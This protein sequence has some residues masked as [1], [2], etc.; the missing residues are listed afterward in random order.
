MG[1]LH[2]IRPDG[3]KLIISGVVSQSTLQHGGY[4]HGVIPEALI[5]RASET[6]ATPAEARGSEVK[7]KEGT[8]QELV[9]DNIDGRLTMEVVT[10]MH[11][12]GTVLRVILPG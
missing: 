8:G 2:C 1:Q 12:V 7:S 10:S 5:T 3:L 6:T 11:E 9:A 4:V